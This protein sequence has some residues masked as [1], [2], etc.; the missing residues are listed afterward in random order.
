M[1]SRIAVASSDGIVVNQ[2]FG[3]AKVFYILE[4]D[5][6]DKEQFEVVEVRRVDAL[7][8]CGNLDDAQLKK[9]IQ[10]V[11][12]CDY[13][14]VSR[15][16]YSAESEVEAA[17]IKVYELPGIISESVK[18]LLSYAEIQNLIGELSGD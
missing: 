11:I 7:C 12:D 1:K 4:A 15:I 8:E 6:A 2:H 5:T 14:L 17:G 3:R 9:S 18:R 13:L 10:N 16:G